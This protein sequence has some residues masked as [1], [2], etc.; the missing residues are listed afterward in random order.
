MTSVET[1]NAKT[2]RKVDHYQMYPQPGNPTG[3]AAP[4]NEP[5]RTAG[6][7]TQV[8]AAENAGDIGTKDISTFLFPNAYL[9]S[10]NQCCVLGFHTYDIEP[11]SALNG[12]QERRYVLN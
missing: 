10:G 9:F 6:T 8:C 4:K 12:W 3:T 2:D 7:Q 1:P 11:G 5:K